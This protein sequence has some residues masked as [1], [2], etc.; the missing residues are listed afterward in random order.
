M[1]NI[2]IITLHVGYSNVCIILKKRAY[3]E[4]VHN[5][6]NVRYRD[7]ASVYNMKKCCSGTC[8]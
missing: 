7:L 4:S 1:Y 6:Q 2:R 5:L 8:I 3:L